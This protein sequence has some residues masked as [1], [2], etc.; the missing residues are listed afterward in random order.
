MMSHTYNRPPLCSRVCLQIQKIPRC[1]GLGGL[2]TT[3]SGLLS[4]AEGTGSPRNKAKTQQHESQGHTTS[5]RGPSGAFS[6]PYPVLGLSWLWVS[7]FSTFTHQSMHLVPQ[8]KPLL[9]VLGAPKPSFFPY[10]SPSWLRLWPE[11][12]RQHHI[13]G[14]SGVASESTEPQFS[15]SAVTGTI[16]LPHGLVVW[17]WESQRSAPRQRRWQDYFHWDGPLISDD[18]ARVQIF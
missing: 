17:L 4:A 18:T 1:G 7:E 12:L 13:W 3:Q 14:W 15:E 8:T 2:G 9:H 11:A 5:G 16:P 10:H 6:T